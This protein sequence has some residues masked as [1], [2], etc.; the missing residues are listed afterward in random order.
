MTRLAVLAFSLTI[1]A[2]YAQD[3][4]NWRAVSKTAR[5]IT[6]DLALST[7]KVSINFVAF[8]ISPTRVLTPAEIAA[9][10][11]LDAVP[12]STATLYR[13]DIPAQK[14]FLHNNTLCAGDTTQW[15]VAWA[16]GRELEVAFF[17]GPKIPVFTHEAI[18]TSTDLCG[19]YTYAR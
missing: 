1:T 4:G 7:T 13:L 6:G 18:S 2:L 19:A 8:P 11:D 16:N 17:S 5:A 14:R 15:M 10:F 12:V 3:N 9:L